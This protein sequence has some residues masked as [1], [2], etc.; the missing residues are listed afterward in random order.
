MRKTLILILIILGS[1][2]LRAQD[3]SKEIKLGYNFQEMGSVE[4]GF[5][6]SLGYPEDPLLFYTSKLR[7]YGGTQLIFD[8][9]TFLLAPTIG[10]EFYWK[11][12]HTRLSFW[13]ATDFEKNNLYLTPEIGVSLIGQ[14]YLTYGY[15]LLLGDAEDFKIGN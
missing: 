3:K 5:A 13:S 2:V 4:L 1:F 15:N 7:F 11:F 8:K 14:L 10:S 12:I 9:N 6:Y